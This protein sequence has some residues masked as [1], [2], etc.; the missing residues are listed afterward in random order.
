MTAGGERASCLHEVCRP[1]TSPRHLVAWS[2][3]QLGSRASP[4][5]PVVIRPRSLNGDFGL[6]SSLRR[7]ATAKA[8]PVYLQEPTYLRRAGTA[9]QCHQETFPIRNRSPP[10]WSYAHWRQLCQARHVRRCCRR[11]ALRQGP[12]RHWLQV[13]GR[14]TSP[15]SRPSESQGSCSALIPVSH[16]NG[17]H[18]IEMSPKKRLIYHPVRAASAPAPFDLAYKRCQM[19]LTLFFM[20]PPKVRLVLRRVQRIRQPIRHPLGGQRVSRQRG[21]ADADRMMRPLAP[22]DRGDTT[23]PRRHCFGRRQT[24]QDPT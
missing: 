3:V 12:I 9:G 23:P 19:S 1:S 8:L 10:C 20:T 15:A 16:G 22:L 13:G 17:V 6:G 7:P 18:R 2:W 24:G 11:T 14:N 5:S 4:T 21:V